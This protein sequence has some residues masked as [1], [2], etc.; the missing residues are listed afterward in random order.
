MRLEDITVLM[1]SREQVVPVVWE[2]SR[3]MLEREVL[4][5]S[6]ANVTVKWLVTMEVLVRAGMLKGV[7]GLERNMGK[8]AGHVLKVGLEVEPAA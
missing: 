5:G 7:T 2:H 6:Q 1:V 8:V 4:G 3:L